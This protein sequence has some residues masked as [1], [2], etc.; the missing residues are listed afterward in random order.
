MLHVFGTN[1]TIFLAINYL[2]ENLAD[3]F[4]LPFPKTIR[5]I[6]KANNIPIF[7]INS[8]NSDHFYDLVLCNNI[9]LVVSVSASEIF[10]KK[11][12]GLPKFGCINLHNAPLPKYKGMFP[13]FWQMLHNEKYSVL[14]IHWMTEDLDAG[15][16]ILQDQTEITTNTSLHE[17]MLE[18]KKKSAHSLMKALDM[19]AGGNV[20]LIENNPSL[21]TFFSFP[22]CQDVKRFRKIGKR[23]I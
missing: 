5:R 14:T 21:S 18:T 7:T 12:L 22:T 13:N 23:I 20:R 15:P 8:V 11:I 3:T 10:R 6:I 17:L 16:I 9:D 1:Y 2:L 4:N 19:I